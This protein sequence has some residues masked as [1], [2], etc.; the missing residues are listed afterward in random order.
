MGA[1]NGKGWLGSLLAMGSLVIGLG[2]IFVQGA[3][4]DAN[5]ADGSYANDCC[6]TIVLRDGRMVLE[7]RTSV[8]YQL[9]T[10]QA[11]PYLLPKTYV[12]TWEERGFEIDGSRAPMKLRLDALPKPTR[13]EVPAVKGSRRFERKPPRPFKGPPW[14]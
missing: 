7:E 13:I 1:V 12:G 8:D 14:A 9:G 2:T 3:G 11:G 10:D 6:G 5:S 4:L